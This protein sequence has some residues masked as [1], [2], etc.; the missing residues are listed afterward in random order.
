MQTILIEEEIEYLDEDMKHLFLK[1]L[2][3]N[4]E[5]ST[6]SWNGSGYFIDEEQKE[7][8]V[9][10]DE[11]VLGL[12]EGFDVLVKFTTNWIK[13]KFLNLEVSSDLD[14]VKE[15]TIFFLIRLLILRHINN[16]FKIKYLIR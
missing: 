12:P 7:H 8:F 5:D 15:S 14:S 1:Y 9:S 10:L 6:K 3:K 2:N 16:I 11:I 13:G 4:L